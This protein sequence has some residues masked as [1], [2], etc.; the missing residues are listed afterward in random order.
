[1][2]SDPNRDSYT[3]CVQGVTY[4]KMNDLQSAIVALEQGVKLNATSENDWCKSAL[5]VV[6]QEILAP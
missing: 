5:E 2:S 6:Q 4:I 3:Y 1:M